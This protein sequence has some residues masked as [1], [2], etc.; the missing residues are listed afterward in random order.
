MSIDAVEFV[1]RLEGT[2]TFEIDVSGVHT[3][4][5]CPRQR[6][7]PLRAA[8]RLVL[9]AAAAASRGSTASAS[10]KATVAPGRE[11]DHEIIKKYD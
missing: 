7:P 10:S 2:C 11:I 5:R 1:F 3:A 9:L 6:R 4:L 8:L